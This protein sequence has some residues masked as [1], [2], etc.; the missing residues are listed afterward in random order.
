MGRQPAEGNE[1]SFTDL[2]GE[3]IGDGKK[4]IHTEARLYQ[5]IA[6]HRVEKASGGAMMLLSGALLINAAVIVLLGGAALALALY[7]GPLLAALIV[8]VVTTLAGLLLVRFGLKKMKALAG[9]AEE[10]AA[11]DAGK[12]LA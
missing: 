10:K 8:S 11:L 9:D 7:V 12:G 6:K 1:P 4:L 5:E 3:L 2:I